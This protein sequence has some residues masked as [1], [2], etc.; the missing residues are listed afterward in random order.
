MAKLKNGLLV[1]LSKITLKA[2]IHTVNLYFLTINGSKCES[3]PSMFNCN[4]QRKLNKITKLNY[5]NIFS[6]FTV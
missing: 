6:N 5:L 3:I 2:E 4:N 1:M